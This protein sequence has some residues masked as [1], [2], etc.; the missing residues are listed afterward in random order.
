M[1]VAI[2]LLDFARANRSASL[3]DIARPA[4][5]VL[6]DDCYGRHSRAAL[7]ALDKLRRFLVDA[8][9]APRPIIV[10]QAGHGLAP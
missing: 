1:Q 5:A 9:K 6:A 4:A 8:G 10:R 3:G 7:L 2:L